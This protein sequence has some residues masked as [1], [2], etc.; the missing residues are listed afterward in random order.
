[1]TSLNMIEPLLRNINKDEYIIDDDKHGGKTLHN[2]I[3]LELNSA[4]KPNAWKFDNRIYFKKPGK[5]SYH[6]PKLYRSTR[7]ANT[8]G[9]ILERIFIS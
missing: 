9:T 2:L 3:K 8:L 4:C 6:A 1:M 5:K 7:L